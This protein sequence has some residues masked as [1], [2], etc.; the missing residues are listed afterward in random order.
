MEWLEI[1][2]V[3]PPGSFKPQLWPPARRGAGAALR[4][5]P[6]AL[7]NCRFPKKP[8]V[9]LKNHAGLCGFDVG[10]L[11]FAGD[12]QQQAAC[13]LNPVEPVGRLGTAAGKAARGARR[14]AS[15]AARACP[16]ARPCARCCR[17][18]A[19][20]MLAAELSRPV[21]HAHDD[22]PLSR[23]ATY[24]IIHDTSTPNYRA[25]AWPRV[26]RRRSQDQQSRA[27]PMRQQDRAR[28][29]LHQSR[30]APICSRTISRCRG[31]RP[32]SK[33]RCS[34]ARR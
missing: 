7:G 25:L 17:S 11:S 9:I 10:T 6:A 18:A 15:A 21:S 3:I 27:L 29:Y 31:A 2:R 20:S 19:S 8:P 13:L 28:A 22:D 34:T 12:P 1:T 32:N 26:D 16:T 24:F 4:P 14:S 33:W 30:P 5:T 23:P